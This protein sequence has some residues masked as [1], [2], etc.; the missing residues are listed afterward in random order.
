[1]AYLTG[2]WNQSVTTTER[3]AWATYAAAVPIK[4]RLG[5]TV[6]ATGF[7]HFVRYMS[8]W[9]RKTGIPSGEAPS[10]LALPQKDPSFAVAASVANGLSVSFDITQPWYTIAQSALVVFQGQPQLKTRNFFNGPWKLAGYCDMGVASPHILAPPMTLI[11]GQKVWCYGR[12]MTGLVD[13]RLSEPMVVSATV[14]A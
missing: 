4:N 6:Y 14:G 3:S 12:I 11:L 8:I 9:F 10:V 13:R 7:N 2:F 5:E 1:M